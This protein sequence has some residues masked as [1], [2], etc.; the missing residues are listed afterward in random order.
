MVQQKYEAMRK[1]SMVIGNKGDSG[2]VW[3]GY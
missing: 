3:E 1:E 2:L